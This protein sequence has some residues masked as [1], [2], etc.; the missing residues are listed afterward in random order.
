MKEKSYNISWVDMGGVIK[1]V[2]FSE[3]TFEVMERYKGQ[4]R[5]VRKM[6]GAKFP[7]KVKKQMKKFIAKTTGADVRNV[8]F[9]GKGEFV[10]EPQ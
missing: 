2:V 7:R 4:A 8:R 6:L 1:P 5:R 3:T 9:V 10:Y